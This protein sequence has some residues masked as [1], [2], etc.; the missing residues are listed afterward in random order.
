M[1][2]SHN[3]NW[4]VTGDHAGYVKYWQSNMNNVKMFQAHKE[5]LRGIRYTKAPLLSPLHRNCP[6]S[7]YIILLYSI[8]KFQFLI[9]L[10]KNANNKKLR[11]LS[12]NISEISAL[13]TPIIYFKLGGAYF[14]TIF[15]RCFFILRNDRCG[16]L[17]ITLT[18]KLHFSNHPNWNIFQVS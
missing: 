4:M 8:I 11:L 18:I 5:A 2:W 17:Y 16:L 15:V 6:F 13:S 1:V 3:D 7:L 12:N 14:C 10:L 9:N